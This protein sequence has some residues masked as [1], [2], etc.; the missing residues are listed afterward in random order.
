MEAGDLRRA[1]LVFS[2]LLEVDE[3]QPVAH[4]TLGL[5]LVKLGEPQLAMGAYKRALELD[6]RDEKTR[7]NAAALMC[8]YGDVEGAKKELARVKS[9]PS[10][11]DVD[12]DYMRCRR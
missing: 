5:L 9:T 6:G 2:R 1:R 7:A 11:P 8:K 4:A 12:P 10:G 3:N